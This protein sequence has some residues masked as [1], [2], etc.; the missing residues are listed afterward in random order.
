MSM[1]TPGVGTQVHAQHRKQPGCARWRKLQR[2]T[3]ALAREPVAL[4]TAAADF[5][6]DA[7]SDMIT[8]LAPVETRAAKNSSIAGCR[9]QVGAKFCEEARAG[10]SHLAAVVAE[11]DVALCCQRIGDRN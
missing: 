6:A 10:R 8:P 9:R 4:Q 2:T 11:S 7:S 1:S 5:S 3:V